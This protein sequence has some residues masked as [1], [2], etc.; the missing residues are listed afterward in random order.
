MKNNANEPN[1]FL[2]FSVLKVYPLARFIRLNHAMHGTTKIWLTCTYIKAD[3]SFA[4]TERDRTKELAVGPRHSPSLFISS[5]FLFLSSSSPSS[6]P[7]RLAYW[8]RWNLNYITVHSW[9]LM[10]RH[11]HHVVI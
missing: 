11:R 1:C 8:R 2:V 6:L 5:L 3:S 4:H 9:Q 10:S 7:R